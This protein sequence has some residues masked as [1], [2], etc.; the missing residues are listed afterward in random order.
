MWRPRRPFIRWGPPLLRRPGGC[1]FRPISSLITLA[2]LILV[3]IVVVLL[4]RR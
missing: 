3:V 4:L 1:I 2:I